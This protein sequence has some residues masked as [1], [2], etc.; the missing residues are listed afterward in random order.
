MTIVY[1]KF[2]N[3]VIIRIALGSQQILYDSIEDMI[4]LCG[5]Y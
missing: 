3:V 5:G 1:E 4:A 2:S